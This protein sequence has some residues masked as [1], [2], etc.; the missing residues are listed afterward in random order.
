MRSLDVKFGFLEDNC[1]K[2]NRFDGNTGSLP[3]CREN[4]LEQNHA[5]LLN[6][7]INYKE[8]TIN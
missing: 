1:F 3:S 7:L 8:V 5:L 6:G 2:T 4:S